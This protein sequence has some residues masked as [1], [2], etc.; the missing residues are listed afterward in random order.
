MRGGLRAALSLAPSADD[1]ARARRAVQRCAMRRSSYVHGEHPLSSRCDAMLIV[2]SRRVPA[3]HARQSAPRRCSD[4]QR[5]SVPEKMPRR[6]DEI[7]AAQ[8]A[9]ARSMFD[10]PC[11]VA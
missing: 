2:R 11:H 8:S 10:A 3:R 6:R 4:A 5:R 1:D 7:V 9:S